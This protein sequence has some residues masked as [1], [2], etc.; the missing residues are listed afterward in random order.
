MRAGVPTI[1]TPVFG[2]QYD[3]S[4]AVQSMGVGIGFEEQ[5]QKIEAIDLSKAIDAVTDDPAM[6]VRAKEV[7]ERMRNEFGC[8]AVVDTVENYWREEVTT[9]RLFSE[10]KDWKVAT[11][12]LKSSNEKKTLR[13]RV[14]LVLVLAIASIAFLIH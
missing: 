14:A 9:G 10:I 4:F 5:L 6:V 3:N 8:R 12:E 2:D 1:V 11:K 13:S 7:G